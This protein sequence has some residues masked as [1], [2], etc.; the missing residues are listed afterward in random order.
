MGLKKICVGLHTLKVKLWFRVCSSKENHGEDSSNAETW[1]EE[2]DIVFF[3]FFSQFYCKQVLLQK[4]I[5]SYQE[6]FKLFFPAVLG[7]LITCW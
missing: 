4:A 6:S 5:Q 1:K 7:L 3:F 2:Q